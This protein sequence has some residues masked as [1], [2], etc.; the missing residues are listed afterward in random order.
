MAEVVFCLIE[1]PDILDPPH[2]QHHD[3]FSRSTSWSNAPCMFSRSRM[4]LF[5][6]SGVTGLFAAHCRAANINR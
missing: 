5:I 6:I 4:I 3:A 1:E 2:R